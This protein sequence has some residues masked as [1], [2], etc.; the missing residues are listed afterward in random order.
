MRRLP[1]LR[2][3]WAAAAVDVAL[4]ARGG[5][6]HYRVT[7]PLLMPLLAAH[8][9][10]VDG[11]ED[12]KRLVGAGLALSGIGDAALL[13]EGE[14]PFAVGLAS[15]LAAH[16]CYLSALAKRSRGGARRRTWAAVLYGL[17][18]CALNVVLLPRT[19]RLRVPVLVYAAVLAVMAIA[20]LD[21]DEPRLTAG[22]AAF[23]ASDILL[24]LDAFEVA[25]VPY[26]DGAVM[27]LYTAAQA[28]I[29]TG[30]VRPRTG[31]LG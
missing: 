13:A 22:G 17:A 30:L 12:T 1:A 16:L 3:Y 11:S 20:A 10:R 14:G 19:G 21:T 31:E 23:V 4:G 18:W 28:L 2:L 7:K 15:F 6:K 5:P 26:K 8:V 24:A 29:A 25:K 27:A 9:A